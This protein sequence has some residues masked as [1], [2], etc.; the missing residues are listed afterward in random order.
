M[1][2]SPWGYRPLEIIRTPR[3]VS[4]VGSPKW[5]ASPSI[6]CTQVGSSRAHQS[7]LI[8]LQP[9]PLVHILRVCIT[10]MVHGAL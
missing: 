1:N 5:P 8:Y 9:G 6:A 7:W 4:T 10:L 3:T 2:D